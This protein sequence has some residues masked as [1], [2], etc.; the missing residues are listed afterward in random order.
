MSDGS[1]CFAR[2]FALLSPAAARLLETP[3]DAVAVLR[4]D[5]ERIRLRQPRLKQ[6]QRV[7]GS[8]ARDRRTAARTAARKKL[9]SMPRYD[10][11]ERRDSTSSANT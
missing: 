5:L 1:V 3:A 6:V 4:A 7:Q 10:G 2:R 11:R 9:L 8:E